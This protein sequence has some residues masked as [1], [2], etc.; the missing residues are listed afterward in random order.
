MPQKTLG[1]PLFVSIQRVI[2]KWMQK[3]SD[4]KVFCG[5]TIEVNNEVFVVVK[6]QQV[7]FESASWVPL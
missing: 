1:V 6:E 2:P 4:F 3:A 7:V 5:D